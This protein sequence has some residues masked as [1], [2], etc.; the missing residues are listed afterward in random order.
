MLRDRTSSIC[1]DMEREMRKRW[2]N[3]VNRKNKFLNESEASLKFHIFTFAQFA[4]LRMSLQSSFHQELQMSSEKDWG[5]RKAT[6]S[7]HRGNRTHPRSSYLGWYWKSFTFSQVAIDVV[8]FEFLSFLRLLTVLLPL[9]YAISRSRCR[10]HHSH[11]RRQR[12]LQL[13]RRVS[14]RES[15]AIRPP[16]GEEGERN[17]MNSLFLLQFW[18]S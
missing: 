11:S 7:Y 10:S 14:R 18:I 1:C 13:S 4:R 5:S 15:R 6:Q 8:E 12:H 17:G 16:V 3:P 9:F 2:R